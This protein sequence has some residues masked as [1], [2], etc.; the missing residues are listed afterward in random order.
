[1][2]FSD[3]LKL[4]LLSS[5]NIFNFDEIKIRKHFKQENYYVVNLL[6]YLIKYLF[7]S[8][9]FF[10]ILIYLESKIGIHE[11]ENQFSTAGTFK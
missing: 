3:V 7:S 2:N 10:S 11:K 1:M 6:K 5:F 4:F 9:D 8:L